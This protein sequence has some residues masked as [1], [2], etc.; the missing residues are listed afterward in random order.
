MKYQIAIDLVENYLEKHLEV[1]GQEKKYNFINKFGPKKC[2]GDQIKRDSIRHVYSWNHYAP[3]QWFD[4]TN[5]QE[6]EIDN[7]TNGKVNG[8]ESSM[9]RSP[10]GLVLKHK[11]CSRCNKTFYCSVDC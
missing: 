6:T 8:V 2:P 10:E 3:Q 7:K 5:R 9:C 11:L 1:I 4:Y